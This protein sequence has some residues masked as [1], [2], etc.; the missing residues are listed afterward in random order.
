MNLRILIVAEHASARFGGEAALP[1]HYYRLLRSRKIPVWL[2]VHDRVRPELQELFP[3]DRDQIIYV[4]DTALHLLLDRCGK[5]LPKRVWS[6]TIGFFAGLLTQLTQR[7]IIR[8]LVQQHQ[9]TVIHQPIP[10]SPKQ[11]SMIFDLGAPVVIGPMNGGMDY[12]P[13]FQQRHSRLV[14]FTVYLGRK[15]AHLLNWIIPGK[16]K[17]SA[18]L[19]ANQRTR[20]ALPDGVSKN[21]IE[22]VENGV[23][24]ELWCRN[25]PVYAKSPSSTIHCVFVGRLVDWKAVD[26][27]LLAFK[28]A[29]SQVPI[30]L[31]IIG[32]GKER[33]NLMQQAQA[34]EI[35]GTTIRQSGQVCF[36]GWLTQADCVQQL[37]Q[38][39]IFVLPSLL[40]CGGAVV[41]EAMMLGLPVIAANWGGPADYLD[42]SCGIL[43]EPRSQQQ[44][45][46]DLS[47]SLIML[48][49]HPQL[50]EAMGKN[51][52]NKVRREFDWD[53]KLDR[54]LAIYQKV[55]AGD[56]QPSRNRTYSR[57][58]A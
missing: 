5:F 41:L 48:A 50:R 3:A 4:P 7:R 53:V 16:R 54:M 12:P 8:Q 9:I 24:S 57:K 58:S 13:G 56:S 28:Q 18:L 35:W 1:L 29:S 34:L 10:V 52:Q 38:S 26:L 42:P 25:S 17:A 51:G 32:D 6:F 30:S 22:L 49:Q 43:I 36:A 27:L 37:N 33:E 47:Q 45:V 40:E 46:E 2:L 39:D 31:T 44:F 21:V 14:D 15:S 19:V 11:P 55:T 23:D 20:K